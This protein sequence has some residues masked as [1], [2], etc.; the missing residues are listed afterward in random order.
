MSLKRKMLLRLT[1]VP[2]VAT[3]GA[4]WGLAGCQ[5]IGDVACPEYSADFGASLGAE[6][7]ANVRTFMLA[8]GNFSVL[9]DQMQKDVGD[10]CSNIAKAGG[11]DST[12]WDG[13]EGD[14]RVKAACA[15]AQARIDAVLTAGVSIEFLVE[16]GEC[17]ASIT[18]TSECYAK[19]D[20]N[21]QCTPA[22]LEAHCEPGKLAGSC[23]GECSGS[24]EVQGGAVMCAGT[25]DATCSGACDGNC[26]GRCDG[27]DSTGA[28]AGMCD[29]QCT[30]TCSGTCS[31]RCTYTQPMATCEGTCHGSCSVEF[32]QPYCEGKFDPPE[33]QIDANCKANCEASVEAQAVCTPPKVTYKVVAG[34]SADIDA[35]ATALQENLPVLLVNTATRAETLIDTADTL[36]TSANAIADSSS[37]LGT[38]AAACAGIAADAALSASV[39]VKVSV[40]ASASVSS[41]A[42]ARAGGG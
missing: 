40:Q 41:S 7:D 8:A 30:T 5:T 26:V 24:C 17:K 23:S 34:G 19:C 36:A 28:C 13:L 39:S 15:E 12:K 27:A 16:G 31:G 32:Q 38:K 10:A 21:A 33:C 29:G 25:C 18:A 1:A 14:E 4:V 20:V 2:L 37:S 3:F 35:L 11:G 42:G 6:V 22:Q 9:A